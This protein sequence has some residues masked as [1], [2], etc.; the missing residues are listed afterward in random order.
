MKMNEYDDIEVALMEAFTD[1]K[2]D[3]EIGMPDVEME[4]T[5]IKKSA[6][7][8]RSTTLRK[9]AASVIIVF[10]VTAIAVAAIVVIPNIG[11]LF[12]HKTEHPVVTT[13]QKSVP[14]S[15]DKDRQAVTDTIVKKT[16]PIVFNDV[17]LFN[18]MQTIGK[19]YDV[20]IAFRNEKLT[21]LRLH[22]QY[23]PDERLEDVV[24]RLNMFN[25]IHIT[26]LTDTPEKGVTTLNVE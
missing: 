13:Q 5:R 10:S 12:G 6:S 14:M 8:I 26:I 18:I 7:V 17:E 4:L 9:L 3:A 16:A 11:H 1:E 23:N 15:A 2:T 21:R 25:D 20:T 22:F 24:Q 19:D